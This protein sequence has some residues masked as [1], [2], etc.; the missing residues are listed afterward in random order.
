M[1]WCITD[2]SKQQYV[3]QNIDGELRYSCIGCGRLYKLKRNLTQHQR[4]ECG[5]EP[6]FA[7]TLCPYRAK[8]KGNLKSHLLLKH[9]S[10][11]IP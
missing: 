9:S 3:V 6:Q 11:L 5:K 8:Q 7:C 4:Y 10:T 1:C 2:F